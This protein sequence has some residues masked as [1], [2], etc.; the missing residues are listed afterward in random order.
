MQ[1]QPPSASQHDE[2]LYSEVSPVG[3]RDAVDYSEV[4]GPSPAHDYADLPAATCLD[5]YQE[6]VSRD[7][8]AKLHGRE[9][10]QP[11]LGAGE[12]D[13]YSELPAHEYEDTVYSDLHTVYSELPAASEEGPYAELPP[14]DEDSY[15][16]VTGLPFT[17]PVSS[18]Y[19]IPRD[20]E[21]Q[22]IDVTGRPGTQSA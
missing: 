6:P 12:S 18:V 3:V 10:E 2:G 16:A 22:Y 20:E 4:G 1:D 7:V 14:A 13:I 11:R 9:Y 17:E 19:S 5:E 21:D 8:Y 15:M